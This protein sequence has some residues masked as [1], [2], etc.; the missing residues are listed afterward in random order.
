MNFNKLNGKKRVLAL[1]LF[2]FLFSVVLVNAAVDTVLVDDVF[3]VNTIVDY[4]KPCRFNSTYCSATTSCNFTVKDPEGK[5][6]IENGVASYDA[7][8]GEANISINFDKIGLWQIEMS[9]CDGP[10][11]GCGSETLNAEVTSTGLNNNL[12]FFAILL[13]ISASV[14]GLGLWKA[15]API[16]LLGTFGLYFIAVYILFNGIAGIKDPV[17]TWGTGLITLG[18]A[19]YISTRAGMEIINGG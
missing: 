18:V 11:R 7:T 10:V 19:M 15:D 4:S 8:Y 6:R 9:C 14:I 12:G 16:T 5:R 2:L 3:E 1:S 17:T 13:A